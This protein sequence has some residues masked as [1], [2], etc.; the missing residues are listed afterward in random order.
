MDGH[1]PS[2]FRAEALSSQNSAHLG[3]VLIHQPWGYTV[4]A[5][6]SG[7]LILLVIS[8]AWFGTYTRKTTVSGLLV[9]AEGVLRLTA[10]GTGTLSQVNVTEGQRV[11][12]GDR[13]F[14]LSGE[15]LSSSG[16][17]QESIGKQLHRR[18]AILKRNHV[19]IDDRLAGQMRMLDSRLATIDGELEQFAQEIRLIARREELA[20]MQLQRQQ[21]LVDAGF[22]A[23]AQQQKDE[24]DLLVLQGQRQAIQRSRTSLERERVELQALRQDAKLRHRSEIA[25]LDNGLAMIRQEQAEHEARTQLIST[26]PFAGVVTGLNVQRGQQIA[27]GSLL[28]SLI[29]VDAPL[30][31][32]L[33]ATSRQAGFIEEGQPVLMRYAAYPYQKFGMA[34]GQVDEVAKSPYALQELP[35]HIASAAQPAGPIQIGGELFYR[36]TVKLDAQTIDVYGQ[37]QPLQAGMVLEADVVQDRRRMYEWALEPLYS[38]TRKMA[39]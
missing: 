38:V 37:R 13:L 4:A 17:V 6:V 27:A 28:A 3:R 23:A 8:F 14:I 10:P 9:P 19:L 15:R 11:E 21:K 1:N 31:A 26:A 36:I 12:A 35:P 18:L 33:Y 29:P 30:T 24:A 32:Q 20:R 7:I 16:G 25:D 2:L 34:R 39:H 5:T 22:I